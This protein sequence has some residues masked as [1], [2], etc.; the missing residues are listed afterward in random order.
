[1][2]DYPAH[3]VQ[4]GLGVLRRVDVAVLV[5]VR[6]IA[7]DMCMSV[8]M[9]RLIQMSVLVKMLVCMIVTVFVII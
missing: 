5:A 7:V 4:D 8:F 3:S 1:V 6:T 9:T 2:A